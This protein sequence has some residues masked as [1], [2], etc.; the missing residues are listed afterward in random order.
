M[1]FTTVIL[2]TL[3]ELKLKNKCPTPWNFINQFILSYRFGR[4]FENK[5][6]EAFNTSEGQRKFEA[7]RKTTWGPSVGWKNRTN[8]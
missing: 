1:L 7:L 5:I 2:D 3:N 6:W 4:A 8:R